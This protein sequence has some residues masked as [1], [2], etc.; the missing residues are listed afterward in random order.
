[1]TATSGSALLE[2]GPTGSRLGITP[3][4]TPAT[5]NAIDGDVLRARGDFDFIDALTRAP[6]VTS[7]ATPGNGGTALVVRGFAG[8]AAPQTTE[9]SL[10]KWHL[11]GRD[12]P[13]GAVPGMCVLFLSAGIKIPSS[14]NNNK[15]SREMIHVHKVFPD[16]FGCG[17]AGGSSAGCGPRGG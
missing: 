13:T 17:R 10:S 15:T 5:V 8:Q 3:L 6:G 7:A 1:M 16:C 11:S 9:A 4:E 2:Q 12:A 14:E